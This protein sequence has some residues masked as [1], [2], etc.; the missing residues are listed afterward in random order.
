[1]RIRGQILVLR[2]I[3][4]AQTARERRQTWFYS[5]IQSITQTTVIECAMQFLLSDVL[6]CTNLNTG[7]IDFMK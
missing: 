2:L 3:S 1:M 7:F 4:C 5:Q 6:H